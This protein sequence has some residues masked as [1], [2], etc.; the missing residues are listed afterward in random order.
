[1]NSKVLK[2]Y[3]RNIYKL[4]ASIYAQKLLYNKIQDK[5]ID[6]KNYDGEGFYTKRSYSGLLSN[7]SIFE[8]GMVDYFYTL[9]GTPILGAIVGAVIGIIISVIFHFVGFIDGLFYG[10][11]LGASIAF[12]IFFIV[13]MI[14]IVLYIKDL[15]KIHKHNQLV[16]Q[17]NK[18]VEISNI[19]KIKNTE[20]MIDKLVDEQN[21]IKEKINETQQ[22]L[23]EYYN[24]NIVYPKYRN[25]VAIS[26]F[27]EY[28]SSGRCSQLTGHE[29]AYNI[30]ENEIRLD[31]IILK[32]DEV[33]ERLDEIKANQHML[34][35]EISKANSQIYELSERINNAACKLDN[36]ESNTA[37]SAYYG[38]ISAENTEFLKW[39]RVFER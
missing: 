6:L 20:L 35:S 23:Y 30:Y 13:T 18:R 31:R 22:I 39:V 21:V 17:E 36:I 27:Y 12:A 15:I 2:K 14:T 4:E 29:G 19:E 5:I 38:R 9:L 34:Y 8:D 32:L 33:I 7:Y 10:A 37:V 11:V 26:S 24:Q 25:F 16:E 1:M 28:L 3:I